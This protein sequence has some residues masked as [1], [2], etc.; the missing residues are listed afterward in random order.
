MTQEDDLESNAL[1]KITSK[2]LITSK[3]RRSQI[4]LT[5]DIIKAAA[6][7]R[8]SSQELVDE[9]WMQEVWEWADEFRIHEDTIPRNKDALLALNYIR[10]YYYM[11]HDNDHNYHD[12]T[13]YYLPFL[14]DSICKLSNIEELNVN[15]NNLTSLPESIGSLSILTRLSVNFNNFTSLPESIGNLSNLEELNVNFND[16]TSLTESIGKLS[17]LEELDVS[18]NNI[19]SLPES[20]GNLSNLTKLIIYNNNLTSLPDSIEQIKNNETRNFSYANR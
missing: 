20:I 16:L 8:S 12:L 17:N 1:V 7:S 2:G 10:F 15:F 18:S 6:I 14:S 11:N 13:G 4:S 3:G 5:S 9:S 19:T